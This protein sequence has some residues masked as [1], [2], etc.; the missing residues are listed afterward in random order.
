MDATNLMH[1]NHAPCTQSYAGKKVNDGEC[2][3]LRLP[4]FQKRGQAFEHI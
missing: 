4:D 2:C 3:L 1:E